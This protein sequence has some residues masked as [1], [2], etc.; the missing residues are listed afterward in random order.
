MIRA[1][2]TAAFFLV[3]YLL[4][5]TAFQFPFGAGALLPTLFLCLH[6]GRGTWP[7]PGPARDTSLATSWAS[8]RQLWGAAL[9]DWSL[10]HSY[11]RM[12]RM[13]RK[14]KLRDGRSAE[15]ILAALQ[16]VFS[17]TELSKF[18]SFLFFLPSSP[19][20]AL[21]CSPL[22]HPSTCK[23]A[24][25]SPYFRKKVF[26]IRNNPLFSLPPSVRLCLL[27]LP[28][29]SLSFLLILAQSSLSLIFVSCTK[30]VAPN[31]LHMPAQTPTLNPV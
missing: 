24:I 27:L 1:D 25:I 30:I 5:M 10:G 19:V 20:G 18:P 12:R 29:L 9:L 4:L 3:L 7:S 6:R 31:T 8:Q 16:L 17:V 28:S 13:L 23:Y 15:S 2:V 26:S 11:P 21:F 22:D 14:G